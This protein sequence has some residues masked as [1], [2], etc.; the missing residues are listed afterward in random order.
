MSAGQGNNGPITPNVKRDAHELAG[1]LPEKSGLP[2]DW[3]PVASFDVMRKRAQLLAQI[4]SFMQARD[5]LEVDT[6]VLDSAANPDPAIDSLT[7]IVRFPDAV[8]GR[9][10]Y[11][12]TSPEFAMKRLLAA[13]SGPIYQICK[14]FRDHECGRLHQPEFTLLEW[15][16][17]GFNHHEL[18]DEI[19]ALLVA[20]QFKPPDKTSYADAFLHT[21]GLDPHGAGLTELSNRAAGLGLDSGGGD[22]SLLLDLIF[23]HQVAPHLGTAGPQFIYDYP[24]CQ[25]ALARIRNGQPAV[26]ER[27][28]L[29]ING[30][31]IANGFNELCDISEQYSRFMKDHERRRIRG[32]PELP[33]D[34]R[35]LAAL[36][37]GLPSCAGVALGLDRLLLVLTR[38]R[39]LADVL[40]YPLCSGG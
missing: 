29:F 3:L 14:V 7:S 10:C 22:R 40:S 23:S 26:A 35:L 39:Y 33:V 27:F 18:M 13:G 34:R 8:T 20:L 30:I 2:E 32:Q 5:I 36:A 38:S 17:P 4:R 21:T 11:L 6:P 25:A 19:G 28:E 24:A 12:H 16:R 37:H 15:Y 9:T 31:E 1:T